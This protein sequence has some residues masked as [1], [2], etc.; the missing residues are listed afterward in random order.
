M[1]ECDCS[2]YLFITSSKS[3]YPQFHIQHYTI[4]RHL[5]IPL[6]LLHEYPNAAFVLVIVRVFTINI[7][8]K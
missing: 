7:S 3:H 1:W 8:R 6:L 2:C 5:T 4:K